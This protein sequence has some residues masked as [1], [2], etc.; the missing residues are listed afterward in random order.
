MYDCVLL[1]WSGLTCIL[2]FKR[3]VCTCILRHRRVV[4]IFCDIS[5]SLD[6]NDFAVRTHAERRNVD[7]AGSLPTTLVVRPAAATAQ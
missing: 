4:C 2:K 1:A 3:L 5:R 6:L 7:H